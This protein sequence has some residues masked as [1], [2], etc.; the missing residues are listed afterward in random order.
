MTRTPIKVAPNT[1]RDKLAP[2]SRLNYAKVYTVEYNVKV[3]FIGKIHR[4]SEYQVSADYNSLHPPLS[5]GI[6]PTITAEET[7]TYVGNTTTATYPNTI[8]AYSA[9]NSS[10]PAATGTYSAAASDSTPRSYSDPAYSI[11]YPSASA[12]YPTA[13]SSLQPYGPSNVVGTSLYPASTTY[14]NFAA[15]SQAPVP[16]TSYPTSGVQ[17][18]LQDQADSTAQPTTIGYETDED[19]F[20]ANENS[21]HKKGKSSRRHRK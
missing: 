20:G 14:D 7:S 2:A 5:H 1:A 3:W 9:A 10:F 18:I 11:S 19:L 16:T 13:Q 8:A 15:T 6:P 21:S 17:D 4:D 12:L